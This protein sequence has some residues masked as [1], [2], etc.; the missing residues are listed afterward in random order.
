MSYTPYD[1]AAD[2]V[3]LLEAANCIAYEARDCPKAMH[4]LQAIINVSIRLA[5]EV[6]SDAEAAHDAKLRA[7]VDAIE[8]AKAVLQGVV[9]AT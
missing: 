6:L 3:G 5:G 1:R 7:D 2:L 8:K 4:G 9:G